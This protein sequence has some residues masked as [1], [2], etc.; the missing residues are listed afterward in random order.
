MKK[1]MSKVPG[2][3]TGMLWKKIVSVVMHVFLLMII[4]ILI[5]SNPDGNVSQIHQ[6]MYKMVTC[7]FILCFIAVPYILATNVANI[8][9]RLPLFRR[10]TVFGILMGVVLSFIFVFITSITTFA[11]L[12]S[13]HP[14]DEYETS[15]DD[16]GSYKEKDENVMLL[17]SESNNVEPS[18]EIK[19]K[20]EAELKA[21]KQAEKEAK[22]KAEAEEK[23][24]KQ[25]ELEAKA[26]ADKIAAHRKEIEE[27]EEYAR[28]MG[29]RNEDAKEAYKRHKDYEAFKENAPQYN[30]NELLKSAGASLNNKPVSITGK[31]VFIKESRYGSETATELIVTD[32]KGNNYVAYMLYNVMDCNKGDIVNICGNIRGYGDII[33]ALG[34]SFDVPKIEVLYYSWWSDTSSNNNYTDEYDQYEE[35]Y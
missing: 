11:L 18:K 26:E 35:F 3:R 14:Q 15:R 12:G 8:R 23:A 29:I 17:S 9:D 34:G 10:K 33:N 2:F 27:I 13:Y 4:I 32:D 22:A 7:F 20:E 25:A 16:I 21:R 1:L 19:A 31:V 30:Y 24:K 6:F 28:L 5:S